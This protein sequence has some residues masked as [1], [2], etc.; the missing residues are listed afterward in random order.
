VEAALQQG[1]EALTGAAPDIQQAVAGEAVLA[2]E[3]FDA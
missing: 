3:T 2:R 1:E